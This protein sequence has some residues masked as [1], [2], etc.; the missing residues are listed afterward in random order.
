L[1][2]VIHNESNDV[3]EIIK[4]TG[5][6][7]KADESNNPVLKFDLKLPKAKKTETNEEKPTF[8]SDFRFNLQQNKDKL[9]TVVSI[10]TAELEARLADM[11]QRLAAS[12]SQLYAT[13]VSMS[14]EKRLA[15]EK[16]TV[17]ESKL[18]SQKEQE[19]KMQT[20]S[21]ERLRE[22]CL[23]EANANKEMQHLQLKIKCDDERLRAAIQAQAEA[24]KEIEHLKL[25]IEAEG[26][27]LPEKIETAAIKALDDANEEMRQLKLKIKCDDERA[28]QAQNDANKEIEDL[29][30]EIEAKDKRLRE[31]IQTAF[32][33]ED[34]AKEEM[35]HLKLKIKSGDAANK[36]IQQL[37]LKLQ[38]STDPVYLHDQYNKLRESLTT[39]NLRI[40]SISDSD[41]LE[42]AVQERDE[43]FA[44]A[45]ALKAKYESIFGTYDNSV[46]TPETITRSFDFGS[47][48]YGN[49]SSQL[50]FSATVDNQSAASKMQYAVL[51]DLKNFL[52]YETNRR[53]IQKGERI[54]SWKRY[55]FQDI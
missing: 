42:V 51:D 28:I 37:K 25:K 33:A 22:A 2:T 32:Q 11:G 17:F 49:A 10:R 23:A 46:N 34:N 29:K 8:G 4:Q 35:R 52:T 12:E 36:E 39:I 53:N 50:N 18:Q 27:R 3:P 55:A 13:K 21:N 1:R 24:N 9:S 40:E 6:P 43:L 31:K 44:K 30:F 48:E 7:N 16:I 15:N 19:K 20:A 38:A 41:E 14:N 5:I 54:L 47:Y 26:E 45:A